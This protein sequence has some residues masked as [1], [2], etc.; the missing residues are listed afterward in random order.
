MKP[1][2]LKETLTNTGRAAL[3][4]VNET[5]GTA[6]EKSAL[7]VQNGVRY[8]RN[9]PIPVIAVAA[10][11]GFA[12][13][14]LIARRSPVAQTWR[15]RYLDDHLDSARDWLKERGNAVADAAQ[16]GLKNAG[17][18]I[19]DARTRI[20]DLDVSDYVDPLVE[21]AKRARSRLNFWK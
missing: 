4:R 10:V 21:G 9:N 8:V 6:R 14:W 3:G 2:D 13:A 16:R 7:S 18:V 5:F 17:E 19:D 15:E 12:A 1:E 11:V 20:S